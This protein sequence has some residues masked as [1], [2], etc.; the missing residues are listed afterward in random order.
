[1]DPITRKIVNLYIESMDENYVAE[2]MGMPL[3]L[4]DHILKLNGIKKDQ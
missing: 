4:V 3:M 1:M 2:R